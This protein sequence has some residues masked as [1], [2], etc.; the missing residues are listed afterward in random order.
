[1]VPPQLAEHMLLD[2]IDDLNQVI[3][4]RAQD[5][6]ASDDAFASV[7]VD[8]SYG[9]RALRDPST[10]ARSVAFAFVPYE[11]RKIEVRGLVPSTR[12][13][14]IA[15]GAGL[16]EQ[17]PLLRRHPRGVLVSKV[18][19]AG[20][21]VEVGE[22]I[23]LPTASGVRKLRVLGEVEDFAWPSGTVYMRIGRYHRLYRTGAVSA[24][25][26]NRRAKLDLPALQR[27]APLHAISGAEFK[28]RIDAQMEKSTQG[29]LAMRV[30]TLV[31]ALVAVGG[32]VTTSVFARRREW[33]VLRAM[34]IGNAG[35]LAALAL[36][37]LLVMAIGAV[38][39][40]IGGVVSY[41]GPTLAFL[42]AQGYVVGHELQVGAVTAI[43]VA[44]VAIG[45]LAAALPAWLTARAPLADALSYE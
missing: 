35:L 9:R 44:A 2:R 5:V 36:E 40:A 28:R 15:P 17:Y 19:A 16:P 8:L 23:P 13:G 21:G 38:C 29:L 30:L 24:L 1:V 41:R 31:A 32:I 27:L 33:A 3:R 42:E 20:L 11:G 43:A 7:P 14:L 4:P 37:T 18:M 10:V 25:A 6:L 22:R 39:G 34:G 26:V 12:A 45:T